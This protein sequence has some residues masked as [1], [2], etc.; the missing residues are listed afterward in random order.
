MPSLDDHFRALTRVQPPVEWPEL[1]GWEPRA[2]AG[3]PTLRRRVGVATLAFAL[4][5]AALVLAIHAFEKSPRPT[6]LASTPDGSI[7]VPTDAIPEGTLLVQTETGAEILRAGSDTSSLVPGLRAPSDLSPDGSTVIGLASEAGSPADELVAVDLRSGEQQAL[8]RAERG[9]VLGAFARWSPDGSMIAYVVGAQDPTERST[10]CVVAVAPTEPDC[11][12]DVG[13]VYD[14]DWAPDGGRLVVAGPP[15][16]PV[17]IL[18][19]AT[20][21]VSDVVPQEGDTPINDAIREAELGT[22]FQLVGPTWSP[23]G[24]YLA[25]LANLRD[26]RFAYVPVVLTPDG[27]FVALGRPSGEFPEPLAW[28]PVTDVLAYTRG[29]APY[30][31]TEAYLVDLATGEERVLSRGDGA[32]PLVITRL[33]WAPSGRWLVFGGW[34]DL[35]EGHFQTSFRVLE[36]A[37]PTSLRQFPVATGEVTN[38]IVDWGP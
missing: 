26:S 28:S 4:A 12:P 6:Q 38:F 9:D 10:L 14:F 27:R 3:P 36:S 17:R 37:D 24:A 19:V 35:G 25:A 15:A 22:S 31:V 30:R 5:G 32:D 20:G 23:S 18:D 1:E 16:Q 21:E 8:V 29:E 13:R 7:T 33:A 34:L 11:F 2:P